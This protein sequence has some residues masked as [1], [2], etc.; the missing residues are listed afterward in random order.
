MPDL[1][2]Q[3]AVQKF[4]MEEVALGEQFLDQGSYCL[5][6]YFHILLFL[7]RNRKRTSTCWLFCISWTEHCTNDSIVGQLD[8]KTTNL[9]M[10]CIDR[11]KGCVVR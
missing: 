3:A 9:L 6:L 10:Y 11:R 8:I 1:G 4:F 7:T 5:L 2:D